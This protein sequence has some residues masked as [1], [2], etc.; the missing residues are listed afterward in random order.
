MLMHRDRRSDAVQAAKGA[1]PLR[2]RLESAHGGVERLVR[3]TSPAF[4]PLLA[5]DSLQTITTT[6]EGGERP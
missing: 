6:S 1:P 4:A 3:A 5:T 2:G